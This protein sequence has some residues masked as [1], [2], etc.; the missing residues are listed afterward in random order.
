M[1][2]PKTGDDSSG[3]GVGVTGGRIV[4][5]DGRSLADLAEQVGR[6]GLRLVVRPHHHSARMPSRMLMTPARKNITVSEGRGVSTKLLG[7][8]SCPRKDTARERRI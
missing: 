6:L 7:G 5:Y 3:R 4:G 2:I 8:K 1:I